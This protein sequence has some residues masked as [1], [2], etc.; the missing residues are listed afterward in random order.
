MAL[1]GLTFKPGTDDLREAP[2]LT[3]AAAAIAAGAEVV[4]YDP[5]ASARTRAARMIPGLQIAESAAE[6]LAGADV[7]GLVTEWSEFTQLDW[8]ALRDTMRRP[9]IVDGRNALDPEAMA[10]AGFRH[11]GFGRRAAPPSRPRSPAGTSSPGHPSPR[12]V[13]PRPGHADR[14]A[15]IGGGVTKMAKI[16][17]ILVGAGLGA[18]VGSQSAQPVLVGAA[19]IA[20]GVVAVAATAILQRRPTSASGASTE[21]GWRAFEREI[22]RARRYDHPMTLVRVQVPDEAGRWYDRLAPHLREVDV[23]WQRSVGH[24]ARGSRSR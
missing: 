18:L 2:S 5:M 21:E 20:L 8:A 13:L 19:L 14:S 11:T 12:F 16:A 6:A 10:A 9:A 7:A 1:L 24:L 4:A 22:A 3:I 17:T 15:T 23:A